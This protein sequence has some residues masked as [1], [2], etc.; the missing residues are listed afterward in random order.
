[1][2]IGRTRAGDWPGTRAE[3]FLQPLTRVR[4]EVQ[5]GD[6]DF[7]PLIEGRVVAQRFEMGGGPNESQA[8]I[9]AQ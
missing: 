9:V 1:M 6:G 2:P 5:I 4:I 8:V 3:A 7:V